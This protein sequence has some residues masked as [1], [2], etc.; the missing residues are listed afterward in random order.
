MRRI[1]A[2]QGISLFELIIALMISTALVV[3]IAPSFSKFLDE[4]RLRA[5]TETLAFTLLHAKAEAIKR[6]H[7]VRVSFKSTADRWC[8]GTHPATCNCYNTGS[9]SLGSQSSSSFKNINMEI[10][11]S[12]PGDHLSFDGIG[13]KMDGT[14]GHIALKSSRGKEVHVIISRSAR[15]RLC[16]PKGQNYLQ[17]FS[18]DC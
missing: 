14:F 18:S 7:Q 4:H 12:S 17:G 5:A 15:I 8:Y 3:I 1:T 10:H 2:A 16:S 6:N 11:I 13:W 9:C